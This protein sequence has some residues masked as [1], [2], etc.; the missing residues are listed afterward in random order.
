MNQRIEC[1]Q[2]R[3]AQDG[4]DGAFYATSANLQYFLDDVSY[5]WQRTPY[6]GFAIPGPNGHQLNV[7][8]CVFYIPAEGQ[9]ILFAS[10]ARAQDMGH[11]PCHLVTDYFCRMTDMLAGYVT[12][13]YF[14]L[15]ESCEGFLRQIISEFLP[16]AQFSDGEHY[17]AEM[18]ARKDEKEIAA[19][20]ALAAFTDEAMG[21]VTEML[22]PGVT[23]AQVE[24]YIGQLG[25]EYGCR[26]LPFAPTVRFYQ[27]GA[28]EPFQVD[29]Y[30]TP[31]VLRPGCSISFDFGYTKDGYCTDFGRSF[32]SGPAPKEIKDA[33]KAL[34]EAQVALI[35]TLRPG[36][37]MTR[38]FDFIRRHMDQ[39]GYGK[40]L[41]R[42]YHFN[43]LGHQVG[44]DVHE[45]PWLHDQQTALFQPGMIF[46][47]E[48]KFW[49]PGQCFTRVEDMILITETAA[50]CLTN[51]DR[52][53]FELPID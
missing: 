48:P 19:I 9:P 34:Q 28:D 2:R 7:P 20:R 40:F 25:Y 12:G 29:G 47:I 27:T 41:R 32:Y 39:T 46:T 45:G 35:E 14:A 8:D 52:T 36:E 21:K 26:E 13:Q 33:Y 15:G 53:L 31:A 51:F 49:W 10:Y 44:I 1:L 18:R 11:L 6:T 43:L 50:E 5:T 22:R 16:Q 42:Y 23:N 3:L 4:V 17:G 24:A 38:G 37:P 30:R